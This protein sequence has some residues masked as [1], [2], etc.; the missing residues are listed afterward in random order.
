MV[1]IMTRSTA[2]RLQPHATIPPKNAMGSDVG[3]RAGHRAAKSLV[4]LLLALVVA[5]S[6]GAQEP[7]GPAANALATRDLFIKAARSYLGVRYQSG[8]T[9]A[10]GMDCSGLVYRSY[11][12]ATGETIPRTVSALSDATAR[13]HDT[14]RESGD[15]L[16]FDTTGRLTHVGIYLGGGT[17]IHS[18]SDGPRTGV[19]VSSLSEDYWARAYRHAGRLIPASG[20]HVPEAGGGS[21][22]ASNPF[23]FT[24]ST[25]FR[26]SLIGS[27]HWDFMEAPFVR[28]GQALAEVS[29]MR[30]VS[31]YPGIG[32]GLSGDARSESVSVPL[33]FSLSFEGG[34][35][36]FVGTQFHL[37]AA[38]GLST[39]PIFPGIIGASWTS[40]PATIFG[41]KVRFY[42]SAEFSHFSAETFDGGFRL[43]TGVSIPYDL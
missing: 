15:L 21:A 37:T 42:Q 7:K 34:F 35:R 20:V 30:G 13:V 36:I 14:A 16:F 38:S 4:P 23:P 32:V 12:D 8:G 9:T 5:A 3:S 1:R 11:L 19:I 29:L 17:F 26:L 41:Q 31:V 28:G 40:K 18:A 10:T 2:S 24:G 27:A 22:P 6:L 33:W 39:S 43:S 25:P